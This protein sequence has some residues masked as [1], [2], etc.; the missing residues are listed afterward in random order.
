LIL[1]RLIKVENQLS[2]E[3]ELDQS[4]SKKNLDHS[5][6]TFY[7]RIRYWNG[8]IVNIE[9]KEDG[10]LLTIDFLQKSSTTTCYDEL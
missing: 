7:L 9:R 2:I 5:K 8:K 3:M 4:K 10:I 1:E 6:L